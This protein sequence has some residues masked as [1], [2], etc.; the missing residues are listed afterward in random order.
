MIAIID[1]EQKA[2]EET[3]A[4]CESE[5]DEYNTNKEKAQDSILELEGKIEELDD[6]IN[7]EETGFKAMIADNEKS[8]KENHDN[9]VSQTAERQEANRAYQTNI[10]NIVVAEGLLV[11]AIKVLKE[12]YAQ[13]EKEE[14]AKLLQE[15]P[16]PPDTWEEEEGGYAGQRDAGGDVIKMLEFI[17]EETQKEETEAH[18]DEEKAQ[19]EFEDDMA[20]LKKEQAKLEESIAELKVDLAEAEKQLGETQIELAKTQEELKGIEKYL[21]KIKPGCDYIEEHFDTRSGN[22][23]SEKA[24]LEE[25]TGLIKDTPAYKAAVHAAKQEALGDC[26]DICNKEGRTHA[27]CEACLAGTSVPGYCAGHK[28]TEG[29]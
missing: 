5:R 26:K 12:Y 21:L 28:D 1:E 29:C 2:D 14:E 18:S 11:K 23:E 24:A 6:S 13:F 25:A 3:K 4:W 19:H 7:N 17:A 27:K 22:R 15:D 20:E 8:L 16:D 9:Q 10:K